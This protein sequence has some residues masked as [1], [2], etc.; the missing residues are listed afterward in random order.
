MIDSHSPQSNDPNL[1]S[2]M[3]QFIAQTKAQQLAILKNMV[4]K[5]EA[6]EILQEAYLKIYLLVQKNPNK[7]QPLQQLILLKPLF[8]SI[9][10]NLAITIIRHQKVVNSHFQASVSDMD[11][12]ELW[13]SQNSED[14]LI[15]Q[16]QEALLL[17]AIN[18]LPPICRQVFVQR[19]IQAKSHSEI[20]AMLGITTKT[21]E[22]HLSKGLILCRNF[23]QKAQQVKNN[24]LRVN[25]N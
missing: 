4:Y 23:V 15:K 2:A 3:Q 25:S 13:Q 10:K 14:E 9:A 6:E 7:Q 8:Y 1:E 16:D 19:K 22:N 12:N 5:G 18:H 20:A 11:A 24:K 17:E 21:V